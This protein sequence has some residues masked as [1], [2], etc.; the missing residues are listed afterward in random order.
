MARRTQIG[1]RFNTLTAQL[2]LGV[3]L[4]HAVLIPTLFGGLVIFLHEGYR[5]SFVN[6]ARSYSSLLATLASKD[7]ASRQLEIFLYESYLGGQLVYAQ[8]VDVDGR[9]LA[10]V[11]DVELHRVFVEDFFFGE[12]GDAVYYISLPILD[13]RQDRVGTLQVGYD[14]SPTDQ[15]IAQVTRFAS[16]FAAGYVLLTLVLVGVWG[17]RLGAPLNHLREL[18]RQV[19]SGRFHE[20]LTV[21]SPLLE[22]DALAA[23]LNLMR[24]ELVRKTESMEFMALHDALT[25]LPN[26]A[27]LDDRMRHAIAHALRNKATVALILLDLD[28]FK[29]INDSL[30]HAAGD[31]VLKQ[32]AERLDA[33]LR[34]SDTVARL[35]GDE[36]ALVL[37]G[38]SRTNMIAVVQKLCHSL[39]Q[40]FQ[41]RGHALNVGLSVGIATFPADGGDFQTLL[42]HADIAMYAA[43]KRHQEFAFYDRSMDQQFVDKLALASDLRR[44]IQNHVLLAYYQ[45]IVRLPDRRVVGYEALA[46]WPHA[47]K[48]LL[49]PGAFIALADKIGMIEELT[50]EIIAQTFEEYPRFPALGGAPKVSINMSARLLQQ[51]GFPGTL[52][53]LLVRNRIEPRHVTLEITENE[54][55]LDPTQALHMLQRLKEL[56]VRLSLDDFG[57]G[58][59]SLEFLK[60]LPVDE[61]KVDKSFVWKMTHDERDANIV[62]AIVALSHTLGLEVTAEGVQDEETMLA[63]CDSGCDLAQGFLIGEPV[64][65]HMVG[66]SAVA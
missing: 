8:V 29:E 22:I 53:E 54:V 47:E 19:A 50:L 23:D 40:P 2:T 59:S 26:R 14:E 20:P 17:R 64:P 16:Y 10:H 57:T 1:A 9:E 6:D 41:I 13:E 52:Q 31:E 28:H 44:D 45:P 4:I 48:G 55:M 18:S 25:G 12:H 61:V 43:K 24:E 38:I 5:T 32:V 33:L 34:A 49:L 21:E 36:F 7:M 63:L 39:Q 65:I 3:L 51:E 30:G 66:S 56:G 35:G 15:L 11:V 37:P 62:R 27:L 58:Y 60:N 42:Q 46:R